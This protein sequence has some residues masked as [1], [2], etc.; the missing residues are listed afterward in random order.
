MKSLHQKQVTNILRVILQNLWLKPEGVS[1]RSILDTLPEKIDF[2]EEELRQSA[3]LPMP[4]Y[5]E[6]A[7]EV[8]NLLVDA[9][10]FVKERDLWNLSEEGRAVCKRI[11]NVEDI[12]L[13]AVKLNEEKN[14]L[15]LTSVYTLE[16]AEE[17]AWHQ[18]WTYLNDMNPLEF[19]KLVYDLIKALGYELDWVAPVGKKH[20]YIDLVA[21]PKPIGSSAPRL[22]VHVGK[23]GQAATMEGLRTFMSELSTQ[24]M[25]IFVSSG[26]FTE[27][28]LAAAHTPELRRVRLISLEHFLKL[29]IQNYEK[30]A[31]EAHQRL[32]L[33]AVYFLAPPK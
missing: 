24:D 27:Q 33:K 7:R 3:F 11:K 9:G 4:Q 23:H 18:I 26:G 28:V 13:A 31:S 12:Y 20:G 21:Y 19:K 8:T 22:K 10:W 6:T 32:P 16:T 5:E 15:L 1:A 2:S 25:G 29:W 30:L 14:R 17:Q